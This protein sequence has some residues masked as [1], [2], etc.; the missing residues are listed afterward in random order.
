ML[1]TMSCTKYQPNPRKRT[2]DQI[3]P[4]FPSLPILSLDAIVVLFPSFP[5]HTLALYDDVIENKS[6]VE[7]CQSIVAS[8]KEEKI[9]SN[10]MDSLDNYLRYARTHALFCF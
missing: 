7:W 2:I 3:T 10:M 8:D 5:P 9:M 4:G 1:S 6:I